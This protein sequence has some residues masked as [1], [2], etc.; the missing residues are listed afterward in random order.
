MTN[1]PTIVPARG[2]G[3]GPGS[4][5]ATRGADRPLRLGVVD[6][7]EVFRIGLR[8]LLDRTDGIAVGWDTGSVH[9]AIARCGTDPVDAVLMDVNLGGPLDGLQATRMLRAAHAGLK[10]VL[11]SG[12][13]DERILTSA[14]VVGAVG[15]LPKEL[16]GTEMIGA[17]RAMLPAGRDPVRRPVRRMEPI[18]DGSLAGARATLSTREKEVLAEIRLGRT[19]REIAVKLGVSTTTVNKHVHSL[20][21]KLG[22][23]NRAEAAI[24]APS[25]L[26]RP[27]V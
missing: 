14:R 5:G 23:R 3:G 17:L 6:D 27:R 11:M 19:N 13:A 2:G 7:H 9:E 16:S 18:V 24:V 26:S 1:D 20:L 12:L 4:D 10:V 22:V 21:R 25:I 8:S 15:F